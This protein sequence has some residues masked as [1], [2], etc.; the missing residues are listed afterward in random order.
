[1]AK[2]KK[3]SKKAEELLKNFDESAKDWGYVEEAGSYYIRDDSR[4]DYEKDKKA[5]ADYIIRMENELLFFKV[6]RKI[7]KKQEIDRTKKILTIADKEN[8]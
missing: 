1:M 3:L 6:R 7:L 8:S 4:E 2:E 5:L